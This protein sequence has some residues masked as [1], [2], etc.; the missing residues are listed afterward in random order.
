MRA[1][2][3]I[4]TEIRK[5]FISACSNATDQPVL[6]KALGVIGIWLFRYIFSG[7][8][9]ARFGKIVLMSLPQLCVLVAMRFS[10]IPGR[11][12]HE[13]VSIAFIEP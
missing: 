5:G 13:R 2:I 4:V 10:I 1:Q 11:M 9:C 3:L 6:V 8:F 12:V 7:I